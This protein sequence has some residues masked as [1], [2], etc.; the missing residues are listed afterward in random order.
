VGIEAEVN[1]L[2]QA[3]L[4]NA[5]IGKDYDLS[6][7]RNHPDEVATAPNV[8][9]I[10]GP[11]LPGADPGQPGEASTD[12]PALRPSRGLATGHALHG[13]WIDQG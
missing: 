12:D 3:A 7:F 1:N 2:D 4:I 11:P 10:L 9:G 6:F 5:A 8:H 13:L